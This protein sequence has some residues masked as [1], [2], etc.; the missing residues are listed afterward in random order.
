MTRSQNLDIFIHWQFVGSG[1][2]EPKPKTSQF[3]VELKDLID[4]EV[5]CETDINAKMRFEMVAEML[6]DIVNDATH[7]SSDTHFFTLCHAQFKST[8]TAIF[9]VT[10]KED[11]INFSSS[12]SSKIDKALK[13][14]RFGTDD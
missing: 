7:F 9:G 2:M 10:L 5:Y 8:K 4:D 11:N 3:P 6:S 1:R 12:K 13:P 14:I